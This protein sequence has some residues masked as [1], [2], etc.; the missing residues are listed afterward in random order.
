MRGADLYLSGD[1]ASFELRI[2]FDHV[3]PEEDDYQWLWCHCACAVDDFRAEFPLSVTR[4]DFEEFHVQLSRLSAG[5]AKAIEIENTERDFK[6]HLAVRRTGAVTIAGKLTPESRRRATLDFA[7]DSD[8][9]SV[10]TAVRSIAAAL[11][12][13]RKLS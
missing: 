5:E 10:D 12:S 11:A 2:D 3:P 8:L 4:Q 1:E 6:L 13:V 9:A 7:F